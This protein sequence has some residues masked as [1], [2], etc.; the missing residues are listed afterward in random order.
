[1]RP[2]RAKASIKQNAEFNLSNWKKIFSQL[3]RLF[4]AS[5]SGTDRTNC[6]WSKGKPKSI[7]YFPE[8]GCHLGTN[9]SD[10]ET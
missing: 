5:S 2:E 4:F 7:V 10:N 6:R 8:K 9:R 3:E 1:M